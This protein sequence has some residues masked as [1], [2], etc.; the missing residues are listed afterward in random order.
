MYVCFCSIFHH[1]SLTAM[2]TRYL[3][4]S[5]TMMPIR[6]P[7]SCQRR[8]PRS[9]FDRQLRYHNGQRYSCAR[10]AENHTRFGELQGSH[11]S[12]YIYWHRRVLVTVVA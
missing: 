4:H 3:A 12:G 2:D 6:W 7:D 10:R 8:P 11:G 9:L 5:H 1:P